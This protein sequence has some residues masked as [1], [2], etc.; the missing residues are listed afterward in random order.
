MLLMMFRRCSLPYIQKGLHDADQMLRYIWTMS[1]SA[2]K[3]RKEEV[4]KF[5]LFFSEKIKIFLFKMV[6]R[7]VQVVQTDLR[8]LRRCMRP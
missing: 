6:K 4:I 1:Q 5:A 3:K 2:E 7:L 8:A